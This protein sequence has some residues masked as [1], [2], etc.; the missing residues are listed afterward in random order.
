MCKLLEFEKINWT[1]KKGF[2][3]LHNF[4]SHESLIK[5]GLSLG[6][7]ERPLNKTVF[8]KDVFFNLSNFYLMF[9]N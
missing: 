9:C 4:H 2:I 7:F 8:I 3:I 5:K 1:N 6:Q